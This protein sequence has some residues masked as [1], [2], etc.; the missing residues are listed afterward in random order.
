[1]QPRE[2][3]QILLK[4]L[5]PLGVLSSLLYIHPNPILLSSSV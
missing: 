2:R 3:E 1:M 4:L 5:P